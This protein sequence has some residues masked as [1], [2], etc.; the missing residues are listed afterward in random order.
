MYLMQGF[1]FKH[2]FNVSFL[3]LW[4]QCCECYFLMSST[5]YEP[6]SVWLMWEVKQTEVKLT[7]KNWSIWLFDFKIVVQL[8]LNDLIPHDCRW[9]CISV[10]TSVKNQFGFP[11]VEYSGSPPICASSIC[12]FFCGFCFAASVKSHSGTS[13]WWK[14]PKDHELES[15]NLYCFFLC[16][17]LR[18]FFSCFILSGRLPYL[19]FVAIIRKRGRVGSLCVFPSVNVAVVMIYTQP[20]PAA[21]WGG[22]KKGEKLL[23]YTRQ[24]VTAQ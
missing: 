14:P 13:R 11:L 21:I 5:C 22:K 4:A 16:V 23:N 8:I 3:Y 2:I 9:K 15:Y 19:T 10:L 7:T 17:C 20:S 1:I 24:A 12:G 18:F 6:I